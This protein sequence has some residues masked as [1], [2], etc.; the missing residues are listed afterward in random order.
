MCIVHTLP[1]HTSPH[2][3]PLSLSRYQCFKSAWMFQVLH[4]GFRFPKD[5]PSLKTAQLVYDKEVQWTLG[6]I[7]F[8][9]RFLPLRDLQAE[10]FKQ[11]HS[12]W[13]RSSFVYNHYLFFACILVVLLAILLYILRLRRIHQREQRQAEAL[14]L[15]WVE[16]GEALLA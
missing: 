13:L 1:Q 9:T 16:E 7:L 8:K 14:D 4:S 15:L 3:P 12:N 6:A 5:Y 2:Q 11:G 10:S